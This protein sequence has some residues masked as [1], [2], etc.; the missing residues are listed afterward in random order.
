[1]EFALGVFQILLEKLHCKVFV[2]EEAFL[3]AG[4]KHGRTWQVTPVPSKGC[5][6]HRELLQGCRLCWGLLGPSTGLAAV[7]DQNACFVRQ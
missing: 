3:E 4:G 6:V 7:S 1:M 5:G 2:G